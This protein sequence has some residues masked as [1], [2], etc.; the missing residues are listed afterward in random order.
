MYSFFNAGVGYYQGGMKF[1]YKC[2]I[3]AWAFFIHWKL[4]LLFQ[5]H[6]LPAVSDKDKLVHLDLIVVVEE[7]EH[8][9]CQQKLEQNLMDLD[10]SVKC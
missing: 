8:V 4:Q 2:K 6:N 10:S 7:V 5:Q 1:I 3:S 9:D